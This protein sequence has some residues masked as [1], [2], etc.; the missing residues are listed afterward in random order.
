MVVSTMSEG[1]EQAPDLGGQ[2]VATLGPVGTDAEAE[3]SRL[4]AH[5]ALWPSFPAAVERV[6]E[7]GGMALVAAGYLDPTAATRN[8]WVDL[9]FGYRSRLSLK[10]VWEAPTKPMCLA[11]RP[12]A[13]PGVPATIGTLAL[14]PST[15]RLV[16]SAI[17]EDTRIVHVRAKPLAVEAVVTGEADAC[18]GSVDV[19]ERAGLRIVER[20]DPTMVWC[21]YERSDR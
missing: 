14:H 19:V 1:P 21:L 18:V 12:T 5:V 6:A 17:S 11:V 10:A 16:D 15:R 3:A 13:E 7:A 8:S 4:G 2:V 9:H 20:F